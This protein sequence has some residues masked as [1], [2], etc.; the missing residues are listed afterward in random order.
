[1]ASFNST[2]QPLRGK[3]LPPHQVYNLLIYL[4]GF[5]T[6]AVAT[7][8]KLDLPVP[9]FYGIKPRYEIKE[10]QRFIFTN[11]LD[12]SMVPNQNTFEGYLDAYKGA[13]RQRI[14]QLGFYQPDSDPRAQHISLVTAGALS[15]WTQPR[16]TSLESTWYSYL[17]QSAY[18]PGVALAGPQLVGINADPTGMPVYTINDL[19][20]TAL[21]SPIRTATGSPM[22]SM[23][24][25]PAP[26]MTPITISYASGMAS[27]SGARAPGAVPAPFRNT[28]VATA[29]S[30]VSRKNPATAST[31]IAHRPA[32]ASNPGAKAIAI[33]PTTDI[34]VSDA[35]SLTGD[36]DSE[37]AF[38][39]TPD[40]P[41]VASTA[42]VQAFGARPT[43]SAAVPYAAS[44]DQASGSG[45]TSPARPGS[46]DSPRFKNF[47]LIPYQRNSGAP[48]ITLTWA[49]I[50]AFVEVH[51]PNIVP[52]GPFPY[53]MKSYKDALDMEPTIWESDYYW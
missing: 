38:I 5:L 4:D 49:Q 10:F 51:Y 17:G 18:Y 52:K 8:G 1:M 9:V 43:T 12:S 31:T 3:Y 50:R 27:S 6:D 41:V 34:Q 46:S 30:F 35:P 28:L 25:A 20:Q 15:D 47:F 53:E 11:G 23:N 32:M 37:D 33:V 24:N 19:T 42:R 21:Y 22:G 2:Y 36:S 39:R 14:F 44:P 7:L 40:E 16:R 48:P 26:G 13:F 29:A 45:N